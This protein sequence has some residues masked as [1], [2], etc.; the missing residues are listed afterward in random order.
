MFETN[1]NFFSYILESENNN[2]K[3]Y[4]MYGNIINEDKQTK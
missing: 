1:I 4:D 2:Y 3:N